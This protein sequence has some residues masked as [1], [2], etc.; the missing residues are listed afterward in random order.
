LCLFVIA[1]VRFQRPHALNI[2]NGYHNKG[3]SEKRARL[4]AETFK[5]MNATDLGYN[6]C[7]RPDFAMARA[8]HPKIG[9]ER[10]K[11][12]MQGD[13]YCNHTCYWKE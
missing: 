4:W 9:L 12:L 7:Y 3:A 13:G 11:T 5:K 10:T 2:I 6:T 1:Y 8:Y